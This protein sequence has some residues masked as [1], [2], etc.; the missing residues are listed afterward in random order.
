MSTNSIRLRIVV[1][2]V[3]LTLLIDLAPDLHTYSAATSTASKVLTSLAVSLA[4]ASSTSP[5]PSSDKSPT[6][7]PALP[8]VKEP[9]SH[10]A[11]SMLPAAKGPSA[12]STSQG[13]LA[14]PAASASASTPLTPLVSAT[15]ATALATPVPASSEAIGS[16]PYMGWS[17]W[18]L[19]ATTLGGYGKNWLN[20]AN[21]KRMSDYMYS[22]GLQAAGYTYINIDA[23]W[24]SDYSWNPGFDAY[25]RPVANSSRFPDGIS[26]MA[27]Y[28]HGKGQKLGVYFVSGL[29]V[30][31]YNANSPIYGT[32]YHA[33]DIA[34]KPLTKT[35]GWKGAYAIDWSHPAAQAY[36]DSI[37]NQFAA[38]GVDFVKIDGVTP[39]KVI[40]ASTTDN[41]GDVKAWSTALKNC[42]RPIW[43][44]ISWSLDHKYAGLWKQYAN[45]IR[46]DTDV[47]SYSD[48]LVT[49]GNSVDDRFSDLPEWLD[50]IGNGAW[51]D[52]DSL[53]IGSGQSID[54]ISDTERQSCMTLWAIASSPLYMG[55]DLGKLDAYGKSLLT[56]PEVIAVNQSALIPAQIV[57]GN[58]QVW[59][60][61]NPDGSYNVALFNLGNST[62]VTTV[63]WKDLGFSG[64]K[65]VRDLWSRTDLGGY[66]DKFSAKLA[67][68]GSR[69]IK[70]YP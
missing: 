14:T 21:V 20:E 3:I 9:S 53:N 16:K 30:N 11:S 61:K 36:I 52:L 37:A 57:S 28:V 42:G 12:F 18:S 5:A 45:G 34:V 56:N 33:R 50:D 32:K 44:T 31:V 38:W 49:W 22:T 17:S 46:I 62:S 59:T 29:D 27:S 69:F 8:E 2:A 41:R 35:N 7:S 66:T 64:S 40:P 1:A 26:G 70:V 19:E 47:E 51:A 68:H 54:G 63:N 6:P 15:Q 10:G 23:G 4:R 13:A 24:W 58:N 60:S 67:P 43:Y 65:K 39:N 55:D 48:T 25:G